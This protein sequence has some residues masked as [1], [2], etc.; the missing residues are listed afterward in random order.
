LTIVVPGVPEMSDENFI[1]HLEA[2][3]ADALKMRWIGRHGKVMAARSAWGIYHD[4]LHKHNDF[5]HRHRKE[6]S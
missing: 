3:H 1:N 5:D 2:R 6:S 4:W